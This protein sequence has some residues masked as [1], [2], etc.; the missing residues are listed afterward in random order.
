[1]DSEKKVALVVDD[2]ALT[3]KFIVDYLKPLEMEVLQTS[4]GKDAMSFLLA[5]KIDVLLL[6]LLMPDVTG[7]EVL[8]FMRKKE[9][10]IPTIIISA[11][12]QDSTRKRCFELGAFAVTHK[13]P[14]ESE[15]QEAVQKALGLGGGTNE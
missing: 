13:P 14:K 6:D 8:E 1:M 9:I 2:S 7:W 4:N 5:K 11:D 10:Q 3:R 15:L 12:V